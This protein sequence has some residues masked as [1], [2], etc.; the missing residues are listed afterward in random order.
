MKTTTWTRCPIP[1]PTII[2]A[3]DISSA[4]NNDSTDYIS[5]YGP[6]HLE[7]YHHAQLRNHV[8]DAKLNVFYPG[9]WMDPSC[10]G[11]FRL[12]LNIPNGLH[13]QTGQNECHQK[14]EW[15]FRSNARIVSAYFDDSTKEDGRNVALRHV[16][17]ETVEH[18]IRNEKV[19][20]HV[21]YFCLDATQSCSVLTLELDTRPKDA[22]DVYVY[23][24]DEGDDNDDDACLSK[25]HDE[26]ESILFPP[27]CISLQTCT[28][29]EN[30]L[31]EEIHFE[32]WEWRP[33]KKNSK[34]IDFEPKWD[35]IY[36]CFTSNCPLEMNGCKFE[37]FKCSQHQIKEGNTNDV[38]DT[39]DS[40]WVFP[41]QMSLCVD[42]TISSVQIPITIGQSSSHSE[43]RRLYDFTKEVF[44][45][46]KIT[47]TASTDLSI[48]LRVG[49]TL[50]EAM[51]DVEE[52]FE[53]ST[54]LACA[55]CEH[56][57]VFTSV[58]LLA[59][60]YAQIL[61]SDSP[62]S[63]TSYEVKVEC[64]SRLPRMSMNGS[65]SCLES[66][67][68]SQLDGQIW[69]T[70]AY[71]LQNCIH[72][73]FIVDGIKRDRLPWAGD[74]AVSIMA[75]TYSFADAEC[76]RSTLTV[77]GRCGMDR[78]LQIDDTID[79]VDDTTQQILELVRESHVNGIVD[80]S[81]WYFICHWLYQRYFGDRIFLLQEWGVMRTRLSILLKY[82]SDKDSG[83]L[84]IDN[85]DWVF[86]DWSDSVEKTT[87]L[88]ILWW[89]AL[90]C[91]A[92]MADMMQSQDRSQ[93]ID[94]FSKRIRD[95]QSRIEVHLTNKED[96]QSSYS[97]HA[98]ILGILS[99]LNARLV[100]KA[101]GDWWAPDTSDE[102]W[103]ALLKVRRLNNQS[104]DALFGDKL[105]HVGTPFMKH[106]EC[107]AISRLGYRSRAI[108]TVRNYWGGMLSTGATTF[109]EAYSEKESRDEIAAFYNRP[110]ARSLCHAWGSGPCALL[111]EILLGLRPLSD[112]WDVFLC[113]PLEEC[114]T[115]LS[116]VVQTKHGAI[117]VNLD[118]SRL[119]VVVPEG[120][121]MVFME[122]SYGP[123]THNISR[124][125]LMSMEAV[126]TWSQKYR[127]W[128]HQPNHII[129]QKPDIRGYE[130]ITMTDAPTIYQLPEDSSTYYMSFV[131]FDGVCY[132]SFLAESTDLI[133]WS[134]FRLA[135]AAEGIDEGGVVLGAY[136]YE[137][138]NI[139]APRVLKRINGRF[140]SLYGAYSKKGAYEI[141]P[142]HQG[143]ACSTD[144]LSWIRETEN[145]MS[146]YG[147]GNV[148][149][150]E[151]SSIYQPWLVKH[152]GLYYNFYN[153]KTMPEWIEQIG[154]ATS[155]NLLEWKR[156]EKNPLLCVSNARYDKQFCADAKVFYD[157][158]VK[159][160]VMF[161]FGVG[162]GGAHIMIAFS[163][164]LHHWI[165]DPEPLYYNGDNLSGLDK[166]Y[167]HKISI[168]FANNM[169]YMYY[170]A[171]GDQGRGIGL[172]T[173]R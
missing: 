142:G 153:A 87:A 127:G 27:P 41:H 84:T 148:G 173:S 62:E 50:A 3:T 98:H 44:G 60:R 20:D 149:D 144:G 94:V 170:C 32:S 102:H 11:E 80:F 114:P 81:L 46:V 33:K 5:I 113:D 77:L 95:M 135:M 85:D 73:N 150:W 15:R 72:H 61:I 21:M 24:S 132:N 99:G 145:I 67:D 138:Y 53:Q 40:S 39:F 68:K 83:F 143:L 55:E 28:S 51:N 82:C 96:L 70:A 117:D 18:L 146:I 151:K 158:E 25:S 56:T 121:T 156:Y 162:N 14:W 19:Y 130:N 63:G 58:H 64:I 119:T 10:C 65:F 86:I 36:Q 69:K 35:R 164:D 109:Y 122:R 4:I 78:L 13:E 129:P 131:G 115:M 103:Q 75:N 100:E 49:E 101:S 47:I 7:T 128:H 171:V 48:K 88:Q 16:R 159:H 154:L 91:G 140:Y 105:D 108:D 76:I 52:H 89:W 126:K 107:L 160:W 17:W 31:Q 165:R 34:E 1:N 118:S 141:D 2:N 110:Y 106:L 90:E 42:E 43:S 30:E 97:R 120:T 92:Y 26:A 134:G 124:Y 38:T 125:K 172:I 23:N 37:L 167:A 6:G 8:K 79:G 157:S 112:E 93:D 104:R 116:T 111:P 12:K 169:Y 22:N 137:S 166:S 54:E 163:K 45:K 136:L 59:L 57:L 161:Y 74:L 155:N 168:V 133:S 9:R 152:D 123:G 71:T 66:T 29:S 139:D 147:P